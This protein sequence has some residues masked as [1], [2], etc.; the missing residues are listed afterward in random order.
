MRRVWIGLLAAACWGQMLPDTARFKAALEPY[1]KFEVYKLEGANYAALKARFLDW[2][3]A[4]L[5][6][7]ASIRAMNTE[8]REAGLLSEGL[9]ET[10]E[11]QKNFAGYLDSVEL[12]PVPAGFFAVK[13]GMFAGSFCQYDDTVAIYRQKPFQRIAV[14]NAQDTLSD[15]HHWRALAIG[16]N[17][18]I[19]SSWVLANCT[20]MWNGST[21]RI[22]RLGDGRLE[23][24]FDGG[25]GA[26]AG[27]VAIL[28]ERD[29]VAFRFVTMIR[30]DAATTGEVVDRY[31]VHDRSVRRIA[32]I[33]TSYASFLGRWLGMSRSDAAPFSS[34]EAREAHEGPLDGL[35]K[36]KRA[37][38]CRDG[39]QIEVVIGGKRRVFTVSGNTPETLRMERVGDRLD[40]AC[41]AVGIGP[42]MLTEPGW[43]RMKR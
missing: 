23:N 4:R 18:L 37:A 20:S 39:R 8:L 25:D 10:G 42:V 31:E 36:L 24:V 5:R 33:A 32:P 28:I 19:A 41:R 27:E 21:F 43:A 12:V 40:P 26:Y 7:R 30:D 22:Q 3:D 2:A 17:G 29:T 14:L 6:Q 1:R 13:L 16:D 11:I 38:V 34:A 35:Y 9:Q 15:G